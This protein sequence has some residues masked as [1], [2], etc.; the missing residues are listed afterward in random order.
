METVVIFQWFIRKMLSI[1]LIKY[2]NIFNQSNVTEAKNIWP[3]YQK[4]K[5]KKK[6]MHNLKNEMNPEH[7]SQNAYMS[8]RDFE[9]NVSNRQ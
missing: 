4:K 5:L 2:F 6:E 7:S 1:K 8:I 3:I 9:L